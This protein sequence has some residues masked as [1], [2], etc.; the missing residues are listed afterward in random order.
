MN[1]ET[2][3]GLFSA[4]PEGTRIFIDGNRV[5]FENLT[6]DLLDVAEELSP[7]NKEIKK[8]K[9][10]LAQENVQVTRNIH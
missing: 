3:D 1:E 8:R 2:D 4:L 7:D 6:P 10:L 5:V 9:S